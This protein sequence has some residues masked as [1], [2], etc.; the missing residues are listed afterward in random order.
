MQRYT[1]FLLWLMTISLLAGCNGSSTTKAPQVTASSNL[2]ATK[3]AMATEV[4]A[5]ITADAAA[6]ARMLP[7]STTPPTAIPTKQAT[8]TPTVTV[9]KERRPS[10]LRLHSQT[11]RLSHLD[12]QQHLGPP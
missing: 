7:T 1:A 6:T 4:V 3:V 5:K 2:E 12:P 10:L 11:R 8:D 9:T